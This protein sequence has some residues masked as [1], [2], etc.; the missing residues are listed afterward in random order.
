M[1]VTIT[2]VLFRNTLPGRVGMFR[3][4]RGSIGDFEW[5]LRVYLAT[6]IAFVPGRLATWRVHS[7]Q[8]SASWKTGVFEKALKKIVAGV[9]SE[10]RDSI[11]SP[12]KAIPGWEN[13][14]LGTLEHKHRLT[15]GLHR[16]NLRRSLP[17]FAS[18]AVECLR[19]HP[20]H[21]LSQAIRAFPWPDELE[22]DSA[23]VAERLIELFHAPWPPRRELP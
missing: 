7:E 6:D 20:R 3:T 22:A 17:R 14:I 15:F 4:D 10:Y 19:E 13:H 2:A 16:G 9:L 5:A 18:R 1:W 12:W 23:H 11:P 21:F 8:A